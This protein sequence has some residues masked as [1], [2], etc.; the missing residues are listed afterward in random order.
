MDPGQ[1]CQIDHREEEVADLLQKLGGIAPVQRRLHLV[2]LFP[3]LGQGPGGVGPVEAHSGHAVLDAISLQQRIQSRRQT[4]QHACGFWSLAGLERLPILALAAT[5]EM[6]MPTDHLALEALYDGSA[7]EVPGL[8]GQHD[9]KGQ[10][11]QQ[12]S[13]LPLE[14]FGIRATDRVHDLVGLFQ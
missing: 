14:A 13:Q 9:L 11:Q 3:Y 6:R 12:I 4:A 10:V 7:T 2:Q 5:E 1:P 8:L